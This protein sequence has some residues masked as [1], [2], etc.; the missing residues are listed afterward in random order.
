[1]SRTFARSRPSRAATCRTASAAL[2]DL[3]GS[4]PSTGSGLVEALVLLVAGRCGDAARSA[5]AAHV[6][7]EAEGLPLTTRGCSRS[8]PPPSSAPAIG[9][10]AGDALHS[11]ER[12]G[13]RLRR[14]DRACAHYLRG[15]TAALD[16]D[17]ASAHSES[18]TALAVAVEA[19]IPWFECLARIGL[20]L[21]QV[22]GA[23]R[24]GAEAQLRTAAALAERLRSPWL[25]YRRRNGGGARRLEHRR[26]A[27]RAAT[28]CAPRC[29]AVTSLDCASHSAGARV[30]SRISASTALQPRH[31]ARIRARARPRRQ[32]RAERR[33]RCA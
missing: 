29:D 26:R 19:G 12:L 21:V 7:A 1:M 31:R 17:L 23:D 18:K 5:E 3:R 2:G 30:R 22:D 8:L 28:R 25:S 4:A 32:A 6:T 27:H 33:R 15:W 13:A 11:L 16:G 24:R 10:G 14:G 9:T 20:A